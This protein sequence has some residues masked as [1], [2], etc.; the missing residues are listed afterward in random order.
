MQKFSFANFSEPPSDDPCYPNPCGING[1]CRPSTGGS[2]VCSCAPGY[3]GTPC[4]PECSRNTDCPMDRTCL[5]QKCV[6]P[7]PGVCGVNAEC[8]VVSRSPICRCRD[9]YTGN[10]FSRCYVEGKW[11]FYMSMSNWYLNHSFLMT[12]LFNLKSE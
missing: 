7:C 6:D 1:N 8:T 3:F 5:N 9:G 2:F 11:S 10:P 12:N 4:R